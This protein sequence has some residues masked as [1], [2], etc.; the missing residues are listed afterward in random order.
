MNEIFD[1]VLKA[2]RKLGASDVHLKVGLPPVFR[3][4]GVLRTLKDV[5]PMTG[6]VINAFAVNMMTEPLYERFTTNTEVDLAYATEEGHRYRVNVFRQRGETGMVLRVI[7]AEIPPFDRLNL[8][9]RVRELAR[10]QRGLVLVTGVTGSGK[11][12]T[13]ASLVNL[14]NHERPAHIV[15]IEDPIEYMFRDRRSV[16]NQRELGL[17]THSFAD[18]L[19]AALRQDPDVLLVG[20]MRDLET[21]KTALRAAES[22][23]L[24]LSTLHTL[25]A[26]ETISRVVQMFQPHEQHATRLQLASVLR[27]IV[28]QRLLPRADGRGM[29]PAVELMIN[30]PRVR[31]LISDVNRTKEITDAIRDGDHPYGMVT[32]DQSLVNLVNQQLVEYEV[33]IGASSTPEDF[34][35]QFRGVQDGAA[36]PHLTI[37]SGY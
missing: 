34:A 10:E 37:E 5:P 20:E 7:S 18:A 11:S 24:V 21:V 36:D 26:A 14:I 25:D 19:R 23:H 9:T 35:L 32:F 29:I 16:V 17:D 27:A 2:A 6:D 31:E 33:A 15:T 12:T 8:P 4:R 30:T 1:R 13:L 22:G 3:I 28:S